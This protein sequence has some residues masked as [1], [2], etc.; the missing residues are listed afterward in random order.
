MASDSVASNTG[1]RFL[2]GP[3]PRIFAHR[4]S[5]QQTGHPENSRAAFEAAVR[6]GADILET[7]ARATRD[8]V[9]VLS[10]D[11]IIR[12]TSG[13]YA[14]HRL[15]WA[16]LV[17]LGGVHAPARLDEVLRAMP[18]ARFNIDVKSADAAR[19]VARAIRAARA[20]DRVLL[21]SFSRRR[22]RRTE[23]A[24]GAPVAASAS[25]WETAGILLGLGLPAPHRVPGRGVIALQIPSHLGPVPLVTRRLIQRLAAR[26][27][28]THVWTI[29]DPVTARLLLERGAH[30]II[31]DTVP[32]IRAVVE[33]TTTAP[34]AA[35]E[36]ECSN[37]REG[38][39]Q[40]DRL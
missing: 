22:R 33:P 36:V 17:E 40:L 12:G 32:A 27:I 11:A 9:A 19:P 30:G 25:V 26:G 1:V 4:G 20:E 18:E 3:H 10:H 35:S 21:A 31:T 29:N 15:S 13:N 37:R 7:D 6:D 8:G 24:L 14:V 2:S 34:V 39:T 16:E 23:R 28:E 38:S 5:W